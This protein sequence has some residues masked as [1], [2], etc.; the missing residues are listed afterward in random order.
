MAR[1]LTLSEST[2]PRPNEKLIGHLARFLDLLSPALHPYRRPLENDRVSG[3]RRGMTLTTIEAARGLQWKVVFVMDASDH[4]MPGNHWARR[5]GEVGAAAAGVLRGNH[6]GGRTALL[7]ASP[8]RAA[9]VMTPGPAGCWKSWATSWCTR[10]SS[11]YVQPDMNRRLG[12]GRRCK[13]CAT[14]P[15]PTC[16]LLNQRHGEMTRH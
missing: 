1:L 8:S 13:G 11:P 14:K 6:P 16:R 2:P 10:C 4:V 3:G 7:R 9:G 12:N 15:G 5:R